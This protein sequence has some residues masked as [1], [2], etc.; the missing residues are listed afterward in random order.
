VTKLR[1]DAPY[2]RDDLPQKRRGTCAIRTF[3]LFG[4]TTHH[5][6]STRYL[7]R[8]ID[9]NYASWSSGVLVTPG[10]FAP[11]SA[12]KLQTFARHPTHHPARPRAVFLESAARLYPRAPIC[13]V[14]SRIPVRGHTEKDV[15]S[16][17]PAE[18]YTIHCCGQWH[19]V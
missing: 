11:G 19:C 2:C 16:I 7:H 6:T 15:A 8:S 3:L 14:L 17:L 13:S 10:S 9:H 18:C 4:K 5:L 1:A 12:Q